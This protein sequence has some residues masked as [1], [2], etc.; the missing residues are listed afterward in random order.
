MEFL[1]EYKGL[2]IKHFEGKKN[3]VADALSRT[4]TFKNDPLEGKAH[5]FNMS[6]HLESNPNFVESVAISP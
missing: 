2:I 6:I 4:S 5:I 1:S 3:F